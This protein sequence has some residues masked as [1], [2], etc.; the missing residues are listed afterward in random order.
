VNGSEDSIQHGWWW[1]P[2]DAEHRIPG[3]LD[4]REPGKPI[5]RLF[6]DRQMS[7]S[8]VPVI[9]GEVIGGSEV[10]LHECW[11]ESGRSGWPSDRMKVFEYAPMRTFL[12]TAIPI[13][14][15]AK[16]CKAS[17]EF[18]ELLPWLGSSGIEIQGSF[19]ANYVRP[20][21][22]HADLGFG[23]L[24]IY[25][26]AQSHLALHR[27]S[28]EEV[29]AV[30][31]EL[32]SSLDLDTWHNQVLHPLENFLTLA[33][34]RAV[35]RRA[36]SFR[37]I[38]EPERQQHIPDVVVLERG[39]KGWTPSA[40]PLRPTEMLFSFEDVAEEW[41]GV[42]SKWFVLSEKAGGALS[43]LFSTDY[44]PDMYVEQRFLSILHA[45]EALHRAING[46]TEPDEEHTSRLREI[47][48]GAPDKHRS[49]LEEKL[50][51]SHEFSLRKRIRQL[52]S[53]SGEVGARLVAN[54]RKWVELLV[55]LRG[56]L[57]HRAHEPKENP[58]DFTQYREY[59]DCL[60]LILKD[61]L[62]RQIIADADKAHSVI[63]KSWEFHML[64]RSMGR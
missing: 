49:W 24:D 2:D 40:E 41:Q 1:L 56:G 26:G 33:T 53:E 45:A 42:I 11:L 3:T 8:V 50:R 32:K 43:L 37:P 47:L 31:V 54:P 36:L 57:V 19:G 59:A 25:R 9:L 27:F 4:L 48:D 58:S 10:T 34:G 63:L 18:L 7:L 39:T 5:L 52:I 12:G 64:S 38:I 22:I 35:L 51:Y 21:P 29:A 30:G 15:D 28:V 23:S 46:G 60:A 44:K 16:F 13:K 14:Q 62:L 61:A 20:E 55:D 17:V 6:A